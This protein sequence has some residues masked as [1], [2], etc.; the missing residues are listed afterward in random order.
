V[1]TIAYIVIN[2]NTKSRELGIFCAVILSVSEGSLI[3]NKVFELKN[4]NQE[5]GFSIRAG[6]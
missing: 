1:H 6:K 5:Y 2:V 3:Q 4:P